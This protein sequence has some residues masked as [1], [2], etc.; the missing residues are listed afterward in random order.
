MRGEGPG[1]I[2]PELLEERMRQAGLSP[3][4]CAEPSDAAALLVL[5]NLLAEHSRLDT[6]WSALYLREP[7]VTLTPGKVGK[8]V[9][10]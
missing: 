2:G 1:V 4:R 10:G 5:A 7:D 9:S 3:E 6:D 8:R